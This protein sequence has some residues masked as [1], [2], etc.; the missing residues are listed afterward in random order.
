MLLVLLLSLLLLLGFDDGNGYSDGIDGVDGTDWKS[1]RCN[2]NA[3]TDWVDVKRRGNEIR[4]VAFQ[5]WR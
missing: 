4:I 1:A 5:Q 3:T 2:C